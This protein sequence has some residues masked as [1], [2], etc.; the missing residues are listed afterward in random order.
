MFRTCNI[1]KMS[2]KLYLK[3]TNTN[4]NSKDFILVEVVML[5]KKD[6]GMRID[7]LIAPVNGDKTM[8]VSERKLII[9]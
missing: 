8:W 7:C 6:R 9:K 1:N 4:P 2:N 3:V 5:E